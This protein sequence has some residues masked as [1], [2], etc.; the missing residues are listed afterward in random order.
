MDPIIPF[1]EA[2]RRVADISD[3]EAQVIFRHFKCEQLSVGD[4]YVKKNQI[5]DYIG[6]IESGM[7]RHFY[8]QDGEEVTRWVSLENEFITALGSLISG[9][10]CSHYLQAITNC[11]IWTLKKVD[12]AVLYQTHVA[13]RAFWLRGLEV[14]IMG[15]EDRIYQQLA[16]DAEQRYL[17]F[18]NKYPAFLEK[19]PQ[20]YIASMIGIKP[21]SLSR[22]RKKL[23][24]KGIS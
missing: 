18:I 21:E 22:L 9:E 15:F 1:K 19:V 4:N 23:S 6:F 11:R 10:P 12:W 7:L 16:G 13:I 24:K 2:I 17:F 14:N 5:C 8:L 20:K 3:A